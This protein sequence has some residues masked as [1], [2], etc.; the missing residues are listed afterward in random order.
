[1]CGLIGASAIAETKP[2]AEGAA[3]PAFSL[4]A[5]KDAEHTTYLGVTGK[6]TFG[7]ADIKAEVVV[8]EIFNMY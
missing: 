4:P 5:P 2:P 7:I 6:E 8:I 1:M 3:L